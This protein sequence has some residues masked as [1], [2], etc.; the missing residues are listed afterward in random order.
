MALAVQA[1][2]STWRRLT[3]LSDVHLHAEAPGTHRAWAGAL[4]GLSTD[5]LFILGDLFEAWVGDD[6]L[7]HPTHGAFWR[8]CAETLH[9]ASQRFPIFFM[10]GNRDFLVGDRLL[11]ACGMQRLAD[12][13]VLNAGANDRWLLG[14]GDAWCLADA[15]YQRFRTEVRSTQWQTGFLAQPLETR[16]EQ[17]RAL[18]QQSQQA[19]AMAPLWADVDEA[20]TGALM[21]EHRAHTLIHGHTHR[22]QHGPWAGGRTRWVLS[23]W[24]ADA[25]PPR[26]ALVQAQRVSANTRFNFEE[27]SLL[28]HSQQG[29]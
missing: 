14:H 12:P 27:K 6:V 17:V 9:R 21:A 2:P 19:Q 18:R 1:V 22:P 16:M 8:G 5:A 24:E 20:T 26:L 10:P 23:D 11:A 13:T 25:S 15:P 3:F 29:F 4:E 7:D 28:A